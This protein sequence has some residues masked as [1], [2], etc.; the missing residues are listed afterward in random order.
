MA[1]TTAFSQLV[2]SLEAQFDKPTA[3]RILDEI[4]A[5]CGGERL[6]VPV[7]NP[8]VDIEPGDTPKAIQKKLNVSKSTSY[9][10]V[11]R[12]RI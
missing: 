1:K 7:K 10:L 8:I 6:Y 11:N 5:V 3:K 2:E 12:H 4:I 9:R